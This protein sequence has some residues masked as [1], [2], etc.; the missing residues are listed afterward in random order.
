MKEDLDEQ[1]NSPSD[2]ALLV[3]NVK[4]NQITDNKELKKMAVD[5]LGEEFQENAA[6]DNG[7]T[8]LENL[9]DDEYAKR[10][11]QVEKEKDNIR[12]RFREPVRYIN[13]CFDISELNQ[14]TQQIMT[15]R[16]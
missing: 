6:K 3:R 16:V 14:I 15:K 8:K 7:K 10:E 5:A 13:Y 1:K 2:Y 4:L 11:F 9:I 12:E